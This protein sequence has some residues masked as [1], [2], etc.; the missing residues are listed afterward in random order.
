MY[1]RDAFFIGGEWEPPLGSDHFDVVSPTTEE[2]VGQLPLST[3]QDI[4]A[5]VDAARSAFEEGQ[6][7]NLAISERGEYLLRLLE[8]L[9][10]RLSDVVDLQIDEMGSPYSFILP[11]TQAMF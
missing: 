3:T 6:W 10:S 4:D 7:T 9:R 2:K 8:V 11:A 1:T 5:A